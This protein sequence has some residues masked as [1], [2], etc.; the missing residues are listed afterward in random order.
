MK[1]IGII[2]SVL[3][4]AV[5]VIG[6]GYAL[7]SDSLYIQ[8]TVNTGDIGLEWSCDIPYDDEVKDVSHGECYIIDDT[9]YIEVYN[10]YPCITY[11]FPIDLHGIGSIPVHTAMTLTGGT[12]D[13]SWVMLPN[14]GG[15]QIHQGDTWLGEI[16]IHLDNT[17]EE[18]AVYT[19]SVQLDYWQYNEDDV[20]LPLV[21][22]N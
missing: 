16:M 11:Y 8:G 18:N 3:L 19:F 7:W 17:A 10:A 21:P 4:V 13:P 6:V 1:K 14:L 22:F 9:L 12:G 5:C 15:M 2:C 20:A